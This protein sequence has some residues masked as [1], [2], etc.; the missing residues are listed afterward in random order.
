MNAGTNGNVGIIAAEKPELEVTASHPKLGV[1]AMNKEP[2]NHQADKVAKKAVDGTAEKPA[3]GSDDKKLSA[4]GEKL[5]DDY[6][7]RRKGYGE[8]N[9]VHAEDHDGDC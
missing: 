5:L 7:E 2:A 8:P 1:A 6:I 9:V 4:E 3:N